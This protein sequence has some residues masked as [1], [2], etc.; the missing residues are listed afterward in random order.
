MSIL[1]NDVNRFERFSNDGMNSAFRSRVMVARHRG[2]PLRHQLAARAASRSSGAA[3]R[4]CSP[5]SSSR[6]S[7][8]NTQTFVRPSE[9]ELP[10]GEQPRRDSGH[11]DREHR[12][13]TSP[14]ASRT[15]RGTTS[16]PTGTRSRPESSS[17]RRS[18]SS[19]ESVRPDVRRRRFLGASTART[20][21]PLGE[22]EGGQFVTFILLTQQ[23]IWP[24]A[25]F[26]QII[27][28]YQRAAPASARIFGLMDEPS[29]FRRTP[30]RT[31]S[32]SPRAASSTTTSPS[33]TTT[34]ETIVED[35]SFDV[36]GGDTLALVGPTAQ[37]NRPS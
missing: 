9:S 31:T 13:A 27:N 23:F 24:M 17:S 8:R 20:V 14:T 26:G 21:A 2:H 6:R 16:T 3:H 35:I 12:E 1:S 32:S 37:G 30:T 29:V 7:S 28:M 33:A 11:Q 10:T 34:S 4:R 25:Q 5:T 18:G 22:L 15:F 19:P 36:D